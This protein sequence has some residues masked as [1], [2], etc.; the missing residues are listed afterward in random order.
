ML[1]CIYML[2]YAGVTTE[3][4]PEGYSDSKQFLLVDVTLLCVCVC[5]YSSDDDF[6][7]RL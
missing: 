7:I 6:K 2:K 1:M 5:V 3:R 4:V